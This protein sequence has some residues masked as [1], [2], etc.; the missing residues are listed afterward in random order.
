MNFKLLPL[1][2]GLYHGKERSRPY[3]EGWYF[4]YH[5]VSSGLELAVIPGIYKGKTPV[6]DHC[7]IQVFYE[8]INH[9]IKFNV[10]EFNPA[11]DVFK[12]KIGNNEFSETHV[13]LDIR[14]DDF[15]IKASLENS[16][17]TPLK[18]NI[19]SPSIM[20]PFS[21]LPGMQCN[22]GIISLKHLVKG[23]IMINGADLDAS[24][25]TGYIEKDW[26]RA[27]P[28]SWLWLQ[29]SGIDNNGRDAACMC[30]IAKIPYGGM[31][32]IGLIAVV[33]V[34]SRQY[35]FATY[36][37]SRITRLEKNIVA[38]EIVLKRF[39]YK[40]HIHAESDIFTDLIAP[41][42]TGMDRIIKE[43]LSAGISYSLMHDS[44]I[45]S[46]FTGNHGGLEIS[47]IDSIIYKKDI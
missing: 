9:F 10:S 29:A 16:G 31:K 38:I 26:G 18:T 7:F 1:K 11:K 39:R 12:I 15:T 43:S 24:N 33:S 5:S 41:T 4:K 45:I 3:F 47:E 6:D 30:S 36:N 2:P 17:L 8:N 22:H 20:G 13:K 40:L 21:Y 19:F 44:S 25:L 32:F 14:T 34:G 42:D 27:F 46:E 28:D 37:F 23:S 35:K